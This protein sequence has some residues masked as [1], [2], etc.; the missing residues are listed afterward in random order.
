[1]KI[2]FIITG[3]NRGGA[4]LMLLR[5]IERLDKSFTPYVISLGSGGDLLSDFKKLGVPVTQLGMRSKFPDPFRFYKLVH[6]LKKIQPD[7][8]QTWMYHADLIGGLAAKWTGVKKIFWGIRNSNL[9]REKTSL[10]TRMIVKVCSFLSSKYPTRIISC[11][12]NSSDIHVEL[13]YDGK[14]FH[15]IPNGFDLDIFKPYK[16]ESNTLAR[17]LNIPENKK[18]VGMVARFDPQ[19]NHLGMIEAASKVLNEDRNCTFLFAGRNVDYKN[20]QLLAAIREFRLKEDSDIYLLGI[21]SDIPEILN[22]I[23]LLVCP[24]IYGEAFPNVL[25]ESMS[26]GVPC[27]ATDVG[28]SAFIVGDT[29]I[30][31]PPNDLNA[32]SNAI[33]TMLSKDPTELKDLGKRARQRIESNF[34]INRIVSQYQNLY[35]GM[36]P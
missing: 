1:M 31:V 35:S 13:G 18:I 8:V 4:E 20:E 24:S 34:D 23:D 26:C 32:L 10:S 16:I 11:S 5:L 28:D 29:G 6:Y 27:V 33:L 2:V 17:K 14:K 21:R 25:G 19:K 9:D 7:V 22:S 3:L 30:I 36:T 15:F 12:S